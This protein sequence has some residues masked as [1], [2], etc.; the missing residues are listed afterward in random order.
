MP[1]QKLGMYEQLGLA[2]TLSGVE[3]YRTCTDRQ[4][5][6]R[7]RLSELSW[8]IVSSLYRHGLSEALLSDTV[9][10]LRVAKNDPQ[11]YGDNRPGGTFENGI[12]VIP[13]PRFSYWNL[14][15]YGITGE[16]GYKDFLNVAGIDRSIDY[17]T[18]CGIVGLLL[19]EASVECLDRGDYFIAA[20]DGM[21]AA[22]CIEEMMLDR[23]YRSII[24]GQ[25]Q[26]FARRGGLAAH[27]ETEGAKAAIVAEY[28]AGKFR[29]KAECARWA[30]RRYPAVTAVETVRRWL[31]VADMKR[32]GTTQQAE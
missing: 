3:I 23:G 29:T 30:V 24:K 9:E 4:N 15:E 21:E 19:I 27:R 5:H 26:E 20:A 6:F 12:A 2:R 31:R 13:D 32:K 22:T 14:F 18:M 1:R 7:Q 11:H 25:R 10:K 17:A 28:L 8:G 16:G